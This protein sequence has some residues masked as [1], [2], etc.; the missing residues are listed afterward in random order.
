MEAYDCS[1]IDM[2][3]ACCVD[4][5]WEVFDAD[6]SGQLDKK[7]T[8]RFVRHTLGQLQG[9]DLEDQFTNEEFEQ[10]FKQFDVDGSGLIDR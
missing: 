7:E 8:Q 3:I 9:D 10:C 5:I 6:N 4:E 2:V 1:D